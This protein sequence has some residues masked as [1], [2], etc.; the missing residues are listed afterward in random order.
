VNFINPF[1]F[2]PLIK[3]VAASTLPDV[4]QS[5]TGKAVRGA[6]KDVP[7]LLH[8][9]YVASNAAA[10][11]AEFFSGRIICQ[12]T[13]ASPCVFGNEH[14]AIPL[15]SK[16]K[17]TRVDNFSISGFAAIAGTSL[18][19][20]LSSVAE[21]ASGSALRVLNNR[22]MSIRSSMRESRSALGM[23][24]GNKGERRILPLTF[25]TFQFD[26]DTG[27]YMPTDGSANSV[28]DALRTARGKLGA[29]LTPIYIERSPANRDC[30]FHHGFPV[31]A[32]PAASYDEIK[33]N[34]GRPAD[35]QTLH[36]IEKRRDRERPSLL[37]PYRH[38][39]DKNKL[40]R[41]EV[42]DSTK[43]Q[44]LGI[45]RYLEDPDAEGHASSTFALFIRIPAEWNDNGKFAFDKVDPSLLVPAEAA[46]ASFD[47]IVADEF[48]SAPGD[49]DKV[50]CTELVGQK[51]FKLPRK[52][53]DKPGNPGLRQGDLV[54]FRP[55]SS[56]EIESVSISGIWRE[57][58]R[59]MWGPKTGVP[60]LLDDPEH[61]PMNANREFVTL[62][63]MLFGWVNDVSAQDGDAAECESPLPAYKGRVRISD[64]LSDVL[65]D[66]AQLKNGSP[67]A[68]W[69]DGVRDC[70]PL[71]ILASPK[72]PC[73]EFYLL[74]TSMRGSKSIRQDFIKNGAIKIQGTKYYLVHP[75][76][77]EKNAIQH[78]KT[79][80]EAKDLKQKCFVRPIESGIKFWF[81][82]DFENLSADELGLLCYCLH[83]CD[84]FVHRCGFGKPLGLGAVTLAPVAIAY[85]DRVARY[86]T[87]GIRLGRTKRFAH[88]VGTKK[89]LDA[90]PKHIRDYAGL[91]N[92][93]AS[94]PDL[95][96]TGEEGDSDRR[97]KGVEAL[98]RRFQRKIPTQHQVLK[99]VGSKPEDGVPIQYPPGDGPE[100]KIYKWFVGNRKDSAGRDLQG[101]V[102]QVLTSLTPETTSI[103]ELDED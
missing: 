72:P 6:T 67:H 36:K 102:K 88:V 28:W 46:C 90:I 43:K 48:S 33:W 8:D 7:Q 35:S 89:L 98:A 56:T 96:D 65:L 64:A 3:P 38:D 63:E 99:V 32:I 52:K 5:L 9:R 69:P 80:F 94:F 78:W 26:W 37:R 95:H 15:S 39:P 44:C 58:V 41:V 91:A 86:R 93:S 62:A 11:D 54:F 51:P 101:E 20:M 22:V 50:S 30:S 21:V 61:R 31:A 27:Q 23:V 34:A 68:T 24:F 100:A 18:K 59:W 55:R 84:E 12:L 77:W 57:G 92:Q 76:T 29:D 74:D 85:V 70:F 40:P 97:P 25:P 71:K 16:D 19:G 81:H 66:A 14:Q 103:P 47:A 49:G 87:D 82:I 2:V 83:P 75:D 45:V 10:K 17:T 13:T 73:P 1:H 42:Y 79:Q 53:G 4:Q 60:D